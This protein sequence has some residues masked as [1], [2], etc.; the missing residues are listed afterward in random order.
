[1][2]YLPPFALISRP[3]CV[4]ISVLSAVFFFACLLY[5]ER[6]LQFLFFSV[7]SFL[8]FLLYLS[9]FSFLRFLQFSLPYST[10]S[11]CYLLSYF[12]Y[13]FSLPATSCIG[14][15]ARPEGTHSTF[16]L[17]NLAK[18]TIF[19]CCPHQMGSEVQHNQIRTFF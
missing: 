12:S 19:F 10:L 17:D 18:V 15:T 13:I 16:R 2:L 4:F 3:Y 9:A 6:L 8:C 5:L 11:V 1:M 14:D 7:L